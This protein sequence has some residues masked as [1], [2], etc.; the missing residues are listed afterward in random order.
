MNKVLEVMIRHYISPQQDEWDELLPMAEFAIN[1]AYQESTGD[2]PFYL[3][4]GRHPR[5]LID[6]SLA[7]RLAKTP[8]LLTIGNIQK[9]MVKARK[10]L[11]AAQ[12]RQ[13]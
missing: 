10:C 8:L 7:K 3:N 2:T 1:N 11:Q 6:C 13:E 9:A 5:L 4:F 12:Q